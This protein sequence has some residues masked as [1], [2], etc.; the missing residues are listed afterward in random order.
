MKATSP[1]IVSLFTVIRYPVHH[2]FAGQHF[3]FPQKH[4]LA[5]ELGVRAVSPVSS[6]VPGGWLG[7]SRYC[8]Q[9]PYSSLNALLI[10]WFTE[11]AKRGVHGSGG[12]HCGN[13]GGLRTLLKL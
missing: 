7:N 6:G 3:K 2:L 1:D 10:S 11:A 9:P 8:R 12:T 4:E 5:V 13:K